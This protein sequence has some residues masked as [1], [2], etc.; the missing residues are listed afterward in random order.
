MWRSRFPRSLAGH[1]VGARRRIRREHQPAHQQLA[2]D[3]TGDV[4]LPAQQALPV[5][6]PSAQLV[7]DAVAPL[8]RAAESVEMLQTGL[9]AGL[10][11]PR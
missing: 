11:A 1:R 2:E 8:R 9:D 6:Q 4:G 10:G 3:L 5:G 7:A